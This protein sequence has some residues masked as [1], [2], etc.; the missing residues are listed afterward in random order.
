[1]KKILKKLIFWHRNGNGKLSK[2]AFKGYCDSCCEQGSME[3]NDTI[4]YKE[5]ELKHLDVEGTEGLNLCR[6]CW[7]NQMSWRKTRNRNLDGKY[8][9]LIKEW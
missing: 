1:M 3:D 8:K 7:D 5:K 6:V 2:K 9:Y 4:E